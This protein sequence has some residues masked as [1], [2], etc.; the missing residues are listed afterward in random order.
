MADP[1]YVDAFER[2]NR[3][4]RLDTGG[5]LDLQRE[6]SAPVVVAKGLGQRARPKPVLG[7]PH[8]D[9]PHALWKI[10]CAFH[11]VSRFLNRGHH[12]QHH[13]V[14]A[15]IERARDVMVFPRR[16]AD[17]QRQVGGVHVFCD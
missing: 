14:G 8:R 16:D 4:R 17:D 13:A 1:Q 9:A 6:N 2:G 5:I 12:R 3:V 11:D 10:L 7:Q 15:D